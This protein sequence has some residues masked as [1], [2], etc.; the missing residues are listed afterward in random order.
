M[1]LCPATLFAA[2]LLAGTALADERYD[3]RGAVG[4]LLGA[5]GEFMSTANPGVVQGL[6]LGADLG[7]TW[8]VGYSGNELML[9]GRAAFGG[10]RVEGSVTFGYRGYFGQDRVKTFVDLGAAVHFPLVAVG[11]RVGFGVQYELSPIVGVYAGLA[12]QVGL[13]Q[14][15]RFDGE[16]CLGL[17][18]R[19]YLLE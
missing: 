2:A 8:A 14:A 1:R 5:T 18:L 15:L 19:S 4:L 17:Q 13:G 9:L 6:R 11:P 16:L 10:P 3:H 12:A 7:G